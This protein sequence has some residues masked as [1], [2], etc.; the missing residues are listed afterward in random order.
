MGIPVV[1]EYKYLG[2]FIDDSLNFHLQKDKVQQIQKNFRR[3][4]YYTSLTKLPNEAKT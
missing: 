2:V 4:L 3:V 1:T